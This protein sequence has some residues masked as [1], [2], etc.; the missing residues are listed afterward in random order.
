VKPAA[1]AFRDCSECP[2]LTVSNKGWGGRYADGPGEDGYPG[3]R[4]GRPGWGGRTRGQVPDKRFAASRSQVTVAQWEACVRDNACARLT[5]GRNGGAALD[6]PVTGVSWSDTQVYIKW[7]EYKTGHPYRLLTQME[8]LNFTRTAGRHMA[9][10]NQQ[11]RYSYGDDDYRDMP[12]RD[13]YGQD[14]GGYDG[15]P[16]NA[17]YAG[18]GQQMFEWVADCWGERRDEGRYGGYGYGVYGRPWQGRPRYEREAGD[19][20]GK[21][22]LY[23]RSGRSA[24]PGYALPQRFGDVPERRDPAYTFRVARNY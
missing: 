5:G 22:V 9:G 15:A 19:T 13:T 3:H 20:C 16:G 12:P 21:R 8:W 10:R 4:F 11:P 7:L 23:G 14:N 1:D 24:G 17:D 2:E 18:G 6:A